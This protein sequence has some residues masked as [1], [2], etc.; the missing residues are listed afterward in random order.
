M[1]VCRSIIWFIDIHSNWLKNTRLKPH[2]LMEKSLALKNRYGLAQK[3]VKFESFRNIQP[4]PQWLKKWM[5]Q[6]V[7]FFL[8]SMN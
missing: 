3:N 1:Y 4:M 5:P 2:Q 6:W 7:K 8:D